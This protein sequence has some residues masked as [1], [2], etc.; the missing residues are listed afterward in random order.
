MPL[1]RPA[2]RLAGCFLAWLLLGWQCAAAEVPVELLVGPCAA[3]HGRTGVGAGPSVP[4]IAGQSAAYLSVMLRDF[5]D[6]ERVGSVMGGIARGYS[7]AERAALA[8]HFSRLPRGNPKQVVDEQSA[9][10]GRGVHEAHCERC[11]KDGGRRFEYEA[12]AGPVLAGQW[13]EY[14]AQSIQQF[15]VWSRQTPSEMGVKLLSLESGDI[16]ALAHFY[17]SRR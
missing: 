5:A 9:A 4:N 17:A 6:E 3:C 12:T 16:E 7:A 15:L 8:D 14:L 11:H 1:F 13:L 10:R 2:R